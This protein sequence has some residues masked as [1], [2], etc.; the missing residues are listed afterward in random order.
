M[1][2]NVYLVDVPQ[3]Y[4]SYIPKY[5][6]DGA[7]I[8]SQILHDCDDPEQMMKFYLR[9]YAEKARLVITTRLHCA[10][11]CVAMGVPVILMKDKFSFRFTTLA[12]YVH[13]YTRDEFESID[14]NPKPVEYEAEKKVILQSAARRLREAYDKYGH[15]FDVSQFYETEEI[16][17]PVWV[18]HY[19][20]VIEDVKNCFEE[21]ESILYA[22]W[23]ITQ[24]AD[25][26][27]SYMEEHYKKSKLV[28][29]YDR[30]K[31]IE[32]HGVMSTQE[33][34]GLLQKGVFV[35][36]TAATANEAAIRLFKE[37]GK[38]EYHISTD[39]IGE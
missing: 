11:P 21:K 5:L 32:F 8:R 14:W 22:V 25:L 10:L 1:G 38:T 39:G 26:I 36:V 28:S 4:Y 33:Q 12:R 34:D 20:N 24:K 30:D 9:E 3:K 15:M 35:F 18:E 17:R 31:K 23:G 6:Q 29:V 37:N 16:N 27:C 19:D 7:V 13:V 2:A